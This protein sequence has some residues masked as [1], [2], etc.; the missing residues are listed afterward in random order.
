MSGTE[1][2]V[3]IAMAFLAFAVLWAIVERVRPSIQ[4]KKSRKMPIESFPCVVLD[5]RTVSSGGDEFKFRNTYY[6]TCEFEDGSREEVEVSSHTY[7]LIFVGDDVI[8]EKQGVLIS[9]ERV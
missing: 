3:S 1:I 5:K 8:M 4:E 6:L 2:A 9:I 7:D